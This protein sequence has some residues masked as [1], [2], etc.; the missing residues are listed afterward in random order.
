MSRIVA[1]LPAPVALLVHAGVAHAAA[2]GGSSSFG[3]GGGGGGGFSGGGGGYSGGGTST[4]AGG[5]GSLLII[6]AV[7]AFFVVAAILGVVAE[8]RRRRRRDARA[9]LVRAASAEAAEDDAAFHHEE[10]EREATR[11]FTHVQSAWSARDV[12]G[13]AR[14]CGDDLLVEWRRRLRDFERKGWHNRVEITGGPEIHYVGLVNRERDEE[15][16]VVVLVEATLEDYVVNQRGHRLK[17]NDDDDTSVSLKEYWTLGKR[18]GRWILLSIE[19]LGEGDHHLESQIVASPWSDARLGDEALVETAVA[20]AAP[21]HADVASLVS[22]DLADDA[23]AAA[24]D[25]SLVDARFSPDVLQAAARR[26]IEAWADAVDGS[27]EALLAVAGPDVVRE[28]L[29]PRGDRARV[30]VRGPRLREMAL[31]RLD[32][33]ARPAAMEVELDLEGRRYLEDRDTVA[34]LEGSRDRVAR[35]RERWTFQLDGADGTP[36]RLA[37]ASIAATDGA[38]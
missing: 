26:A 5:V 9:R 35:W 27:D 13:L 34:L 38:V 32:G 20:D 28:L 31:V 3:G 6:L 10:V 17:R 4:G 1:V 25:L 16:R 19:Q 18:D 11:I 12:D 37:A 7:V 30:V 14:L 36:W 15:D 29:Y 8:R 33:E 22:L 23:R 21:D 2:G 24:L